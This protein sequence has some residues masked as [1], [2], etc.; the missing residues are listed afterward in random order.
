[1][2]RISEKIKNYIEKKKTWESGEQNWQP[3]EES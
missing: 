1:M 3:E 2:Y